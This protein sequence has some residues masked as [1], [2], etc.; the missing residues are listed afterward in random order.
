MNRKKIQRSQFALV[1]RK[2]DIFQSKMEKF[3]PVLYLVKKR[4]FKRSLEVPTNTPY[5]KQ[6]YYTSQ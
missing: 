2:E 1:K 3:H 6:I 5:L 4:V